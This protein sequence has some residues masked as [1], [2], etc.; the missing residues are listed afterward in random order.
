MAFVA[1]RGNGSWEVRE[2]H[3]TAEG[4]RS[5]TL[6]SFRTLTPDI[7][8]RAR[9]RARSTFD[10]DALRGAARRAGAPVAPSTSDR[11]SSEL[12]AELV[13]GRRP[14]APLTRLLLGALQAGDG[15]AL[16]SDNAQAAATWIAATPQQRGHALHDLLLLTDSL[17]H[18]RRRKQASFPRI[19][20]KPA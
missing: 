6:A 8:E 10:P 20:S 11:A 19:E 13:A 16:P 15:G 14:R 7:V 17:P 2:S 3:L 9:A 5:R 18:G 4:P 12:I 1:Q